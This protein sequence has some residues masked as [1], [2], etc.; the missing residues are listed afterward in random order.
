MAEAINASELIPYLVEINLDFHPAPWWQ[1]KSESES[2][3][4]IREWK[5]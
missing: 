4:G 1:E 3:N 2:K 5:R